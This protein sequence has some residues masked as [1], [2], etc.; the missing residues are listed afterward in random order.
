MIIKHA[1]IDYSSMDN[2]MNHSSLS[3]SQKQFAAFY[4]K[5]SD[6]THTRLVAV[7]Y[8]VIILEF[9]KIPAKCN[10]V[11]ITSAMVYGEAILISTHVFINTN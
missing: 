10:L 7:V 8:D 1:Y 9:I 2:F 3:N 11:A 5:I 6:F 4:M